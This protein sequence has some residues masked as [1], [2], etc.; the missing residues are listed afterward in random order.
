MPEKD[1]VQ[2]AHQLLVSLEDSDED[3]DEETVRQTWAVELDRR[4]D[5][6]DRG[7]AVMQ[8]RKRSAIRLASRE[9]VATA[10]G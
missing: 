6:V 2:L 9:P 5:R 7:E 8:D 1:R 4:A 10:A 3:A